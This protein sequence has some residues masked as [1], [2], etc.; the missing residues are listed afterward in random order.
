VFS[1]FK[2]QTP[3]VVPSLDEDLVNRLEQA[4]SDINAACNRYE[5]A[6]RKAAQ[7]L[8]DTIAARSRPNRTK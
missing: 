7:I 2:K 6:N 8:S 5:K 4:A 1:G 3:P